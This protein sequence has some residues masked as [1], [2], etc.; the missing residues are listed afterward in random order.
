MKPNA[1]TLLLSGI[2][3]AAIARGQEALSLREAVSQ[4]LR[5]NHALAVS[6]ATVQASRTQVPLARAGRLPQVTY[7]E[8]W[9]RSNNPVFVF[10]SLLTQRQFQERNF[11]IS[12]LNRPDSLDNFQSVLS[13][14]QKLYDAGTTR[15]A[16]RSAELNVE[17]NQEDAARA[18]RDL[19][20]RVA[21]HYFDALLVSEQSAATAQALRSASADLERAQASR[22]AGLSTE[23]D[24]LSLRVHVAALRELQIQRV[25]DL[26][27]ARAALNDDLGLP[28][29][30]PHLLSTPLHASLPAIDTVQ[31]SEASA[32]VSRPEARQAKL[33]LQLAEIQSASARAARL[34]QFD[35]RLALEADRQRFINR[36]G[37]NWLVSVGMRWNLFDGFA[38]RARLSESKAILTRRQAEQQQTDSSLRLEVRRAQSTL[39]SAQERIAVAAASIAAAQESLRI[40]Q[41]RYAAGLNT[42]TDLLRSESALLEARSRHAAAIRDQRLAAVLADHAAGSLNLES[43]VLQDSSR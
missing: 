21:T 8:S 2:V 16:Q 10:S 4:A 23:A 42:V 30:T 1:F 19:I 11:Q 6:A 43:A 15:R 9:T 36:G 28:L 27:I 31:A 26:E 34:P 20:F 39:R 37:A 24:V 25:S 33:L 5:G 40:I 13:A 22:D 7:S 38:T 35:L 17:L 12:T 18:Q 29:D 3:M 14:S 32:L 41:N